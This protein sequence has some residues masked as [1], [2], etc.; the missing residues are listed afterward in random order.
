[1]QRVANTINSAS[2]AKKLNVESR[3]KSG[4]TT[5]RAQTGSTPQATQ[6]TEAG[7]PKTEKEAVPVEFISGNLSYSIKLKSKL[8]N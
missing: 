4:H 7:A 1:M 2:S 3:V 8:A 5:K 6:I